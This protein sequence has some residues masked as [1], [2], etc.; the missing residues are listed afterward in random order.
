ME[1]RVSEGKVFGVSLRATQV[2]IP[3]FVLEA[4]ECLSREEVLN[5]EGLFRKSGNQTDMDKLKKVIDKGNTVDL[6]REN[7]HDVAN[8]L[9]LYFRELPEPLTLTENYE[10]FIAAV[11]TP[12]TEPQARLVTLKKVLAFLPHSHKVVLKHLVVFLM[13]VAHHSDTNKMT[14]ENIATVFAPNLL[15]PPPDLNEDF[16]QSMKLIMEETPL[17]TKLLVLLMENFDFLLKDFP[18]H[19]APEVF[20][21]VMKKLIKEEKNRAKSAAAYK[22]RLYKEREKLALQA[23]KEQKKQL[24]QIKASGQPFQTKFS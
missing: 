4:I 12:D 11:A 10:C 14:P 18:D 3:P 2:N 22:R 6:T 19:L 5:L 7:P 15:K 1:A 20:E 13:K 8:L 9:K 16:R 23:F 24:A 17:A 21:K